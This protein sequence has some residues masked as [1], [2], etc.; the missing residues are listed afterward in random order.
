MKKED[1][2]FHQK[3]AFL[4]FGKFDISRKK[5]EVHFEYQVEGVFIEVAFEKKDTRWV[6][7]NKKLTEK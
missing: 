6:I 2:F 1:L 3:E 4:N 7:R 5:A